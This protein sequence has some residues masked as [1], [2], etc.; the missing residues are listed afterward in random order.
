MDFDNEMR[1]TFKSK[2]ENESF[3]RTAI[4]AF[5]VSLDPT[6]T[7]ISDIKTAVSEA[8][9]NA[10]I[11]GYNRG[12]GEVKVHCGIKNTDIYI[13][14]VDEGCGIDNIDKAREPLYTSKPHEERSGLGFTIM[15]SFMDEMVVESKIGSGTKVSMKKTLQN[16]L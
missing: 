14:V 3:A 15:E 12:S 4:T 16:L 13:E 11:H 1:I 6:V 10:I 8:V 7:E 2:S 5:I 9:T